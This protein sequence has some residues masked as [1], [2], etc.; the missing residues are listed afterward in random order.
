MFACSD[1]RQ[2][3]AGAPRGQGLMRRALLVGSGFFFACLSACSQGSPLQGAQGPQVEPLAGQFGAASKSEF[4]RMAAELAL[5]LFWSQDANSNGA[6]EPEELEVFWGLEASKR[7]AWVHKQQ[8]TARFEQAHAAILARLREGP[9]FAGLDPAEAARRRA[10]LKEFS[11]GYWTLVR[12]DLRDLSDQESQFVRHVLLAGKIIERLYARQMGT[13][14]LDAT[15][16]PDDTLSRSLFFLNHGPRC[17]APATRSDKNCRALKQVQKDLPVGLYPTSLQQE[18]SFCDQLAAHPNGDELL[19]PSTVVIRAKDGQLAAI[20]YSEAFP[21]DMVAVSEELVRAGAALAGTGEDALR[22]YL[23]AAAKAFRDNSWFE[24]DEAWTRMNALN[25]KWYLRIGPDEVY[26]DPCNRKS[27][28]HLSFAR[29]NSDSIKWQK[30]LEP[31]KREMEQALAA[32]AGPPY[33]ERTVAFKMP[34]FIDIVLNAGGSR[35]SR[36]AT[37]GQSLPNF[38]PVANEGRGRTVVMTNFYTDPDSRAFRKAQVASLICSESVSLFPEGNEPQAMGTVLHEAAHNLGPS[39]DYRADG[40]TAREAF[41]GPLASMLE[42]LK[43][44]ISSLYFSEWLVARNVVDPSLARQAH[45]HD[46]AWGF[47]HISRGLYSS[48]GRIRPYGQ[49]SAIITGTLWREG[50]LKWHPETVAAN[51]SDK[52]CFSLRLDRFSNAIV[53]LAKRVLGIKARADVEAALALKAELIDAK[54]PWYDL[55]QTIAERWR[56]FPRASFRYAVRL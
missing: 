45:A 55:M 4:N 39:H 14:G 37:L 46:V 16:P 31:Q 54:G 7:D 32:L 36:G 28:F 40:K 21:K 1:Q 3:A 15:I 30:K 13:Y 43:S 6:L 35:Y 17:T 9:S 23:L 29:I 47:G 33:A 42:E 25:S 11:Q 2:E 27:T 51:G 20:P 56:R 19:A 18:E 38:G 34:E 44:E 12:S 24:A 48:N 50:F 26:S 8:F 52:G 41:G 22:A 10:I 53:G 49:T 5:P